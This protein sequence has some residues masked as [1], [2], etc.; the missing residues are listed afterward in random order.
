VRSL[1]S[2]H[3]V[4]A[5]SRVAW[6]CSTGCPTRS[7]G[8]ETSGSPKVPWFPFEHMPR[9]TTPAAVKDSTRCRPPPG[10]FHV[11]D[12]VGT[13]DLASTAIKPHFGAQLRG[14]CSRCVRFTGEVTLDDATLATEWW[15]HTF[16][17][18]TLTRWGTSLSFVLVVSYILHS[19]R[20]ELAWRTS[21][22]GEPPTVVM[23]VLLRLRGTWLGLGH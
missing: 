11:R 20:P 16:S 5:R 8:T 12:R 4:A 9:S 15:G 14:L 2:I 3:T 18:G 13:E 6:A 19:S 7:F 10:A 17:D 23:P 21:D 22:S 1:S